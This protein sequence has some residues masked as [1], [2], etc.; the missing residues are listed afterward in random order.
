MGILARSHD[1]A[2]LDINIGQVVELLGLKVKR[3]TPTG[4]DLDCPFCGHSG[5]MNI[6]LAKNVYRCNYC[7]K[8]GGV[9]DL[10]RDVRN[11]CSRKEAYAELQK[12]LSCGRKFIGG[13][14]AADMQSKRA[15]NAEA[16]RAPAEVIDHTY[17]KLLE[18]LALK[19]AHFENLISRGL[20]EQQIAHFGFQSTPSHADEIAPT[21]LREGCTLKGVPGFYTDSK[22]IWRINLYPS[23]SGILVPVC[24]AD[25]LIS[26]FQIRLDNPMN[27]RKYIWLSSAAKTNGVSCGSPYHFVGNPTDKTVYITEGSLKADVA[28]SLLGK[29]FGAVAGVSQFGAL[30]DLFSNLKERGIETICEAYDMD[31]K[32]NPNV[33]SARRKMIEIAKKEF[34]FQVYSVSWNEEY[35][36]ID[37]WALARKRQLI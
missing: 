36:G 7:G 14:Q 8:G 33:E 21:L 13:W 37:D 30:R 3:R 17:R 23:C 19:P 34:G 20:T 25:G 27:S 15:V 24:S 6:N 12:E 9:L 32:T 1:C 18:I 4:A 22:D 10:Y 35:K 28:H 16:N 5:K 11:L 29:S 31:C 26:G 2:R